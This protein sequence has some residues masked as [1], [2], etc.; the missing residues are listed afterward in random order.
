MNPRFRKPP[1][2]S[3]PKTPDDV[4]ADELRETCARS[5]AA[6]LKDARLLDR[7]VRSLNLAEMLQLAEACTSAWIVAVSRRIAADRQKVPAP[8]VNLLLGS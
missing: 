4:F 7:Q 3:K 6:H 1:P 5:M 8:Y 2:E